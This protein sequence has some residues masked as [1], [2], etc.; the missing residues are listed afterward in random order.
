M[1]TKANFK[2]YAPVII[3]GLATITVLCSLFGEDSFQRLSGLRAATERQESS[4]QELRA[5]VE[6]LKSSVSSLRSGGRALEKAARNE[7]G[8]V[9]PN[10]QIFIF[11]NRK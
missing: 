8:L 9:R 6:E 4:N 3:I 10:E 7:L 1:V 2:N 11:E 5:R